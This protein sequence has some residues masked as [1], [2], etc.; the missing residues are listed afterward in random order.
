MWYFSGRSGTMKRLNMLC[1]FWGMLVIALGL[2]PAYAQ[3]DYSTATLKGVIYDPQGAVITKAS[4]TVTNANTGFTKTVKSNPDG[5]Y[6]I[7]VLQ[8]GVYQ[9]TFEAP[10]FQKQVV[11]TFTL[12]VGA[13]SIFDAHMKVGT[14]SE[15]V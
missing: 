11:K 7:P 9:I 4:V 6:V 15:T 14:A 12:E 8:P 2:L 13:V 10:G 3:V 1:L 5:S